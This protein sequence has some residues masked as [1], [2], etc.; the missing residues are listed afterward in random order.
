MNGKQKINRFSLLI[1]LAIFV[2]ILGFPIVVTILTSLKSTSEVYT[3]PATW[4]PKDFLFRNYLEIFS[5]LDLV[6]ALKYSL[7]VS[8]S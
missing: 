2:L 4:I 5:K 8:I 1:V 3:I 7:I 6:S